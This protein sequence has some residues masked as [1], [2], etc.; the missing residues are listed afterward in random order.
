MLEKGSTAD[1]PVYA[2]LPSERGCGRKR[3]DTGKIAEMLQMGET[4]TKK[5]NKVVDKFHTSESNLAKQQCYGLQ[6]QRLVMKEIRKIRKSS[7]KDA[8]KARNALARVM[9]HDKDVPH[10]QT[11]S[12]FGPLAKAGK[13]D[14][15]LGGDGAKAMFAMA[16]EI[17]A[18]Y[19]A[20]GDDDEKEDD[21]EEMALS[22]ENVGG[23]TQTIKH[24]S[25]ARSLVMM[26]CDKIEP[27]IWER[28]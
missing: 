1:T 26:P 23:S 4:V 19:T 25:D 9:Q 16:K 18:K 3:E 14:S 5:C 8:K 2:K 21:D 13:K 6:N 20:E 10:N 17:V 22:K 15:S 27:M 24:K 28:F 7:K 12:F 11:T